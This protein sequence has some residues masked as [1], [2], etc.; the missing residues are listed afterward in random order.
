MTSFRTVLNQRI[1]VAFSSQ[2]NT[3]VLDTD[4]FT[5]VSEKPPWVLR[6]IVFVPLMWTQLQS[7]QRQAQVDPRGQQPPLFSVKQNTS[8][9][10]QTYWWNQDLHTPASLHFA[11]SQ[12]F[13][14]PLPGWQVPYDFSH[15]EP[16][17]PCMVL[18]WQAHVQLSRSSVPPSPQSNVHAQP[19]SPPAF[20]LQVNRSPWQL[21]Y[22]IAFFSTTACLSYPM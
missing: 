14:V 15:L 18:P 4:S 1:H 16:W 10:E 3:S 11:A 5:R 9:L 8:V 22:S 2:T 17:N 7:P 12:N 6:E 20:L 19:I 13:D 21:W